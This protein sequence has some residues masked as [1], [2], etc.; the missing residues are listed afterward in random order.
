MEL[1]V[2]GYRMVSY[3]NKQGRQINGMTIYGEYQS[4]RTTGY[5]TY[6]AFV[7]GSDLIPPALGDTIRLYFNRYGRVSTFDVL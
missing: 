7:S 3:V 6:E 1:I 2:L 5:E 4:S